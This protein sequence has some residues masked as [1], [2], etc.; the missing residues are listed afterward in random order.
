MPTRLVLF[1]ASCSALLFFAASGSGY[2]Q[3][4]LT[5][6]PLVTASIDEKKVVSLSGN[7]RPEVRTARDLGAAPE[8]LLLEHIYLLM[9]RPPEQ[10]QAIDELVNELHDR[11]SSHYH[12]WLSAS[13]IAGRFAPNDKDIKTVID[14]LT[15]HD[16]T[17]NMV[18]RANG[19][20][21]FSGSAQQ[22]AATFHTQIHNLDVNGTHHIA[23]TSD[24]QIPSALAPAINGIVSLNDF[25]P[26]PLS[27]V[28]ARPNYSVSIGGSP[29][30]LVV[31]GDLETIYN[32]N[33]LYAA[34]ISGQDQTIVVLEDSDVFTVADWRT[35]RK[36]FGLDA[37]FP[38]GSFKQI[39]PQP[40]FSPDNGGSCADPRVN[41][42]DSEAIADA[43]WA[44]A[45][46]PSAEI[47]VASCADTNTNFGGFIAMQNLLTRQSPPP[48]I[49]SIS[50]GG[51]EESLGETFNAYID[52][53]YELAVLQ[54]VSVFVS[55]GDAGA[56]GN[57]DAIH[58]GCHTRDRSRERLRLI[59]RTTLPWAERISPIR[60]LNRN[61][62]L[63]E[64]KNGPYF[65]SALSYIPEIP[66]NESCASR[67]ISHSS[68]SRCHTGRAGFATARSVKT[69]CSLLPEREDQAAARMVSR[70]SQ[71]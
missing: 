34:G 28:R 18:Y 63:L 51:D 27:R 33:P 48:A 60:S 54:G 24:P 59:H 8:D 6:R 3:R 37:K 13:Q 66:W 25:R 10:K 22:V 49:I 62:Y 1:F 42:D 20:I 5:A 16:F 9:N 29:F 58:L 47:V 50:Y 12:D 40:D 44:T 57:P 43:E 41:P 35:F 39:H 14:W 11:N 38:K 32:M 30:Q 68:G 4:A 15:A 69:T 7:T 55:A 2:A 65:E 61:C 71:K 70:V 53:L 45:T 21:D 17:V 46:A 31:P 52:A 64:L 36:T 19:V 56:A 23:N 67:L 26:R